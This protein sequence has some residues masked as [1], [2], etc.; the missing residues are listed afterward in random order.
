[1]TLMLAKKDAQID[2]GEEEVERE[3]WEEC[4]RMLWLAMVKLPWWWRS[5]LGKI[6]LRREDEEDFVYKVKVD[7]CVCT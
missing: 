1:M 6:V 3:A 4:A 5:A 2:D 7:V